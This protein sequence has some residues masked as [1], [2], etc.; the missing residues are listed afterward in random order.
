MSGELEHLL[1]SKSALLSPPS[2][3]APSPSLCSSSCHQCNMREHASV[4]V[5][6]AP[7][8][9]VGST[10]PHKAVS[11]RCRL[12]LTPLLPLRLARDEP[13]PLA[14]PP[15]SFATAFVVLIVVCEEGA[16]GRRD[17]S[18]AR[19]QQPSVCRHQATT[20]ETPLQ[21][22]LCVC[23]LRLRLRVCCRR[24]LY[25]WRQCRMSC[26]VQAAPPPRYP[27]IVPAPPV[28]QC[29]GSSAVVVRRC[30][31]RRCPRR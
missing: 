18:C 12:P 8:H 14:S 28:L 3:H 30:R 7:G 2:L 13:P 24:C 5:H 23:R 11:S 15:S 9:R 16:G 29:A 19:C 6:R 1:L 31:R 26:K 4:Q 27:C 20:Q 10:K 25:R 22:A 21:P 17:G